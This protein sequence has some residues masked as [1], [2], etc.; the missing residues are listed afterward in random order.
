VTRIRPARVEES[1]RLSEIERLSGERFREV[2]LD[3]VADDE[4]TSPVSY[5]GYVNAQ[6]AWVAE[7]ETGEAVGFV[8]VSEVDGDAHIDQI[9]VV[10]AHQG[11]GLGR[12]LVEQAVTWALE[13]DHRELTLTTFDHVP[14]NRP[15][16]EHLGFRVMLP[17][18]IGPGLRAVLDL[19]AEQGLDPAT[20]VAMVRRLD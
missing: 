20:R 5:A 9:S 4:P 6:R 11:Q 13:C 18:E 16:Y 1:S 8:V 15:L 3:H 7:D 17:A 12:A 10:P 2:G 19:E 14:W